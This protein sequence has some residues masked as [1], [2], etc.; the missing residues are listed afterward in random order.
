MG[1]ISAIF[2][3]RSAS[4]G[5]E[6]AFTI[7]LLHINGLLS[8]IFN[9]IHSFVNETTDRYPLRTLHHA[10]TNINCDRS[11]V[12]ESLNSNHQHVSSWGSNNQIF[13]ALKTLPLYFL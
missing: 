4:Q 8:D 6:F 13:N 2:N 3:E 10:N 1:S 5:S 11:N 7:F 12:G 9:T